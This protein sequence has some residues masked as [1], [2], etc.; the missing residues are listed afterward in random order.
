MTASSSLSRLGQQVIVLTWA[1]L[2]SRYRKTFAGFL[3][4]LLNPLIMFS[5]QAMVF[6]Q[7]LRINVPNFYVFL[8]SGLIPWIFLVQTVQM[9]TPTLVSNAGLMKSFRFHPIVLVGS[10]VLD[11]FVNF[12]LSLLI[13]AIPTMLASEVP[14]ERLLYLPLCL[15]PFLL[16][17]VAISAFT[18][19]FNVFFRDTNFV[20]GFSFAVLFYL[21][22][23]FYPLEFI[24]A[25]LHWVVDCNPF[26]QLLRPFQVA[27]TGADL[28]LF[29]S[30]WWRA[31]AWSSGMAIVSVW[32][33]RRKQN[34]V[35]FHL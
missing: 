25:H 32:Y 13:L 30:V 26:Y 5:V 14:L 8:L 22:P 17:T 9:S 28:S 31:L 6:K 4:V 24:P 35:Y 11:N 15:L 1:A 34:A 16:G 27:I 29:W 3:W 19:L 7:F 33:W 10:V 2:K 21:T 20:L 12:I 23:V 18:A